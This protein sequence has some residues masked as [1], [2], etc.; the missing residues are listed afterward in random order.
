M[1]TFFPLTRKCP[2]RTSW[3]ACGARGGEPEAVDH[4]VEPPLE[5]LQQRLAGDAALT[6]GRLEV[7]AELVLEHPVDALDLLLLAQLHAVA[8]QLLLP[9]LAV[10]PGSEVALLD[11]ALLGVAPLALEEQLHALTAAQA[12]HG[13]TVTSHLVLCL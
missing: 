11:R 4:V 13:T 12:A 5:Q 2:W 1:S 10:L 9:R 3:R 6:V 8:G 7:A